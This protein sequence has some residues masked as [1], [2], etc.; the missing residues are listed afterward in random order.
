MK[1]ENIF[2]ASIISILWWVVI[3]FLFEEAIAFTSGNKR[4]VKV[5]ICMIVVILI[6]IY[7][8]MFPT[9]IVSL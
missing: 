4:H 6:V 8:R 3:W 1:P 5:L 7:T 2:G 9:H